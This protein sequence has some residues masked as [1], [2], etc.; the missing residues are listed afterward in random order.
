MRM[1]RF[2]HNNSKRT[3]PNT[4]TWNITFFCCKLVKAKL[5]Y[6]TQKGEKLREREGPYTYS[7][8]LIGIKEGQRQGE[9]SILTAPISEI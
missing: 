6:V 2:C 9:Y 7:C 1:P 4:I 3:V 5:S 8:S